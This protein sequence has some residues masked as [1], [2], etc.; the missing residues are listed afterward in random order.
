[1]RLG[2][3]FAAFV[4]P[5]AVAALPLLALVVNPFQSTPDDGRLALRDVPISVPA[6]EIAA[7]EPLAYGASNSSSSLDCGDAPGVAVEG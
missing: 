3:F 2:V 6:V 1:M 7:N 5:F 4:V